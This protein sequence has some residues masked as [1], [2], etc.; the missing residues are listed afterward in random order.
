[1]DGRRLAA[2]LRGLL[3]RGVES[4]HEVDDLAAGRLFSLRQLWKSVSFVLGCDYGF[5]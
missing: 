4:G 5:H 3:N 2:A 1:M